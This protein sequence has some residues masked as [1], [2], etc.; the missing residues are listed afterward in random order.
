MK[1]GG[2][3]GFE[4]QPRYPLETEGNAEYEVEVSGLLHAGENSIRV[5][6]GNLAINQ[7]AKGPPDYKALIA[8]YGDRFQP[9]D[10]DNVQ[11]EPAGLFGPIWSIAR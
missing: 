4:V 9:Q 5:V 10:M 7:L 11:P 1:A 3:G 8:K 6:V 2:I